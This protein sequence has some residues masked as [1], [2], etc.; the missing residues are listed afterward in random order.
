MN[1]N[2]SYPIGSRA[3]FSNLILHSAK[4]ILL[5]TIEDGR[6]NMRAV[7]KTNRSDHLV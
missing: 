6:R 4:C 7:T 1:F 3:P 2:K 5:E